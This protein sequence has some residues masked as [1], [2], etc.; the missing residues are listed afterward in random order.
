[1]GDRCCVRHDGCFLWVR[2][3]AVRPERALSLRFGGT[4]PGGSLLRVWPTSG[5]AVGPY[6]RNSPL[7][8]GLEARSW[9]D[10][11]CFSFVSVACFAIS[12]SA[13]AWRFDA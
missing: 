9:V 2:P 6:V 13:R 10:R 5:L 1:M 3:L 4:F 8:G 7:P 11:C 12:A